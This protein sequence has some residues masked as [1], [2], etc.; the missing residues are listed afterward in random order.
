M[1]ARYY[2]PVIGR[3]YSNDPVDASS[4]L[5][6][7]N[8]IHGFNR[9]AYA[10]NNPYKFTDPTDMTSDMVINM[11]NEAEVWMK[12]L[13]FEN[14]SDLNQNG[15]AVAKAAASQVLKNTSDVATAVAIL[16][17]PGRG[18]AGAIYIGVDA[19]DIIHHSENPAVDGAV[20]VAGESFRKQA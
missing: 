19:L 3:F 18:V 20:K 15:K 11:L 16:S 13:G 8:S 7:P 14:Q 5:N 4:H 9:Y 2:D 12:S 6:T 17:P 10:N 1:Q